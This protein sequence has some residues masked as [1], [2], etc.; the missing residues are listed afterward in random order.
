LRNVI[1]LDGNYPA[2]IGE[3][4]A[5]RRALEGERQRHFEARP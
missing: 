4:D 5:K 2:R 1:Q 3:F